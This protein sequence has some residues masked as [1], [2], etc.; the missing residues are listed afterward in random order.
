MKRNSYGSAIVSLRKEQDVSVKML[1]DILLIP[2]EKLLKIESG[3]GE[4]SDVEIRL[5]A[6]VFAVDSD[7][8]MKGI[9]SRPMY[10]E[11]VDAKIRELHSIILTLHAQ[12]EEILNEIKESFP[13]IKQSLEHDLQED[14]LSDA[15]KDIVTD[16]AGMIA[17]DVISDMEEVECQNTQMMHI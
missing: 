4:L 2:S 13:Q 6:E 9:I 1:S 10:H 7:D 8:L 16:N 5:A 15:G 11:N 12:T 3:E 17:E 14:K